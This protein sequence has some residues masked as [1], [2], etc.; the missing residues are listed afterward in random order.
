VAQGNVLEVVGPV[1]DIKFPAGSLPAIYNALKIEDQGKKIDLTVEVAQHLGDDVARCIALATT[2]GLV[3][4]MSV[5]DLGAPISVPVGKAT[6]GRLINVLGEAID[7]KGGIASDKLMPIHRAA[8]TFESQQ[9]ISEVFETGIKVIDL[10]CPFARGGK[11]GLFGGAGV[12]KTVLI[13]ELIRNVAEV[14]KGFSA[15]AGVGERTR[16]GNDLYA[17][18]V[19][20]GRPRTA[21]PR[22]RPDERAA[23][24]ARLASRSGSHDLPST[25]ATR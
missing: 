20:V 19:R 8:P 2:D 16:E 13:Q 22:L 6:L 17:R 3:R 4:G 1:V 15:F 11:V 24:I 12:G 25:S 10:L 23:G 9:A 21:G 18:N 5:R 14:L 7:G